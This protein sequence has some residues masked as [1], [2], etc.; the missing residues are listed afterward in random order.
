[1][2]YILHFTGIHIDGTIASSQESLIVENLFV[3]IIF[4]FCGLTHFR[5]ER[6]R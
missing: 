3:M 2:V 1:M 5:K 4:L 6:P